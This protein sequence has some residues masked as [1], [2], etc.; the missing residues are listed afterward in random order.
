MSELSPRALENAL[1][2]TAPQFEGAFGGGGRAIAKKFVSRF[3]LSGCQALPPLRSQRGEPLSGALSG[4]DFEGA[5][6]IS[7]A[8]LNTPRPRTR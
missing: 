8:H 3:A 5:H 7:R 6:L 4:S 2:I 1:E